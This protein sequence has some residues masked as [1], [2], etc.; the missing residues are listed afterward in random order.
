MQIGHNL[1]LLVALV[2]R[3]LEGVSVAPFDDVMLLSFTLDAGRGFDHAL[4]NLSEQYL[5]K[6]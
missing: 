5:G 4:E 3:E 6:V 1:K 2:A